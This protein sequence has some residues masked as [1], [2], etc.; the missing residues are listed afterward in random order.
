MIKFMLIM[1]ELK[2]GGLINGMMK[3]LMNVI[4]LR[5]HISSMIKYILIMKVLN[6][7]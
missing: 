5:D 4:K 1:E 7:S 6:A 3:C 2:L